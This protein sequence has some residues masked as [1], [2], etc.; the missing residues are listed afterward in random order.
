MIKRLLLAA[1]AAHLFS[2]AAASAA[3]PE[4]TVRIIVP[5]APG[6]VT[7][8]AARLLAQRLTVKWGQSVVIENR[9]GAGGLIGVDA[10]LRAPADGYTILMSTNGE[11]VIHPAASIKPKFNPLTDLIPIAMVTTTPY[12]WAVNVN[13]S[14]KSL[15]D[16]VGAAKAKPGDLSFPSAGTGST[17]HLATEQF[18]ASAGVKMQHVPYRGGAPAATALTSG[19]MQVGLVA[20]SAVSPLVDSGNVR[21]LAVTSK[22]RSKMFPDAPTVA[23]TGVL[24]DFQASIWTALFAPK[25]TP[26]DIVAKIRVDTAEAL[27]DPGFLEKLAAVGT[28]PGDAVGAELTQRMTREI[29]EVSKLAKAANIVLE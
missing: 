13:S 19:E 9:A 23:E 6:G 4:R 25:G 21:I 3:F 28:D 29:D 26:A 20:L 17:M 1:L 7:D 8:L 15:A 10:A 14:Y 16:I 27:K 2:C 18:A 24:K 11:V 22:T 12:A 5:F